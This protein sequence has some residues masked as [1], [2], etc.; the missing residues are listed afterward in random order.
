MQYKFAVTFGTLSIYRANYR[1][2]ILQITQPSQYRCT[3]LQYRF[4]VISEA[5]SMSRH[6]EVGNPGFMLKESIH[7]NKNT[8]NLITNPIAGVC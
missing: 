1:E 3:Q 4:A 5:P 7:I 8:K 6:D 2:Y